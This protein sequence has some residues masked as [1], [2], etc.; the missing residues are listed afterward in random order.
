[1]TQPAKGSRPG[2][3]IAIRGV[4]AIGGPLPDQTEPATT[5]MSVQSV[6]ERRRLMD[7]GGIVRHNR[8]LLSNQ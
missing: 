7:T 2:L 1:M 5:M 3:S 6:S 4:N 8:L